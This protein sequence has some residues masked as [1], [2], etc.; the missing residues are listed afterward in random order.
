MTTAVEAAAAVKSTVI[1][2]AV[3]AAAIPSV[4]VVAKVAAANPEV[5]TIEIVRPNDE[6]ESWI[7]RVIPIRS[8]PIRANVVFGL[9]AV[10]AVDA[11]E[12]SALGDLTSRCTD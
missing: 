11:V 12:W 8:A 2:A 1:A 3:T 9:T 10:I 6:P 4:T 7:E 5:A